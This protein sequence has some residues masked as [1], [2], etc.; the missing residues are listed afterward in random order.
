[1]IGTLITLSSVHCSEEKHR[2]WSLNVSNDIDHI[3]GTTVV[4]AI[5]N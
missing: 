5:P 1:M 4:H 3:I 2:L